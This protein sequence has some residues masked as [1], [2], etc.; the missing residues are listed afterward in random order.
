MG[1]NHDK[2]IPNTITAV[3]SKILF[4]HKEYQPF[5]NSFHYI[6][7]IGKLNYLEKSCRPGIAYIVHKCESFSKDPRKEHREALRWLGKYSKNNI[8]EGN[9]LQLEKGRG[10][11]V[12]VDA[13]FAGNWNRSESEEKDTDRSRHGYVIMFEGCPILHKSHLQTEIALSSTESEYT[14]ISYALR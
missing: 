14:G 13:D 4:S 3:S 8:N 5:D 1:L 2:V 12:W 6:S 9:T 10:L 7:V 11:E